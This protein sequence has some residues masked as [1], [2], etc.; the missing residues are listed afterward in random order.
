M[1][2][3]SSSRYMFVR[4]FLMYQLYTKVVH[5]S[6]GYLQGLRGDL[7]VVTSGIAKGGQPFA[8]ARGVLAFLSFS[9]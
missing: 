2:R 1:W 4:C 7:K 5:M 6:N 9:G 3:S 8:G